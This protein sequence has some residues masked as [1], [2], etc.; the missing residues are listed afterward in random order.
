MW[1]SWIGLKFDIFELMFNEILVTH[2][3]NSQLVYNF[4]EQAIKLFLSFTCF[5]RFLILLLLYGNNDRKLIGVL[6]SFVNRSCWDFSHTRKKKFSLLR[7]KSE[8]SK[9]TLSQNPQFSIS[10][11]VIYKLNLQQ[12]VNNKCLSI[13]TP[14]FDQF[15]MFCSSLLRWGGYKLISL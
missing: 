14:A 6:F 8:F 5:M 12:V 10:Y 4:Y 1:N 11:M 3:H 2:M 13:S 9:M 15:G 7:Q